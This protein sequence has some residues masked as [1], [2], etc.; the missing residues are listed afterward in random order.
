MIGVHL[1]LRPLESTKFFVPENDKSGAGANF[2]VEWHA[3]T[4]VNAALA[5]VV[6]ISLNAGRGVSFASTGKVIREDR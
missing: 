1:T 6:M 2:L 3:E 5:E 4:L